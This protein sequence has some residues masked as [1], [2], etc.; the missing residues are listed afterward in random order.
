MKFSGSMKRTIA[1]SPSRFCPTA[2]ALQPGRPIDRFYREAKS[3]ALLNHPNI[4]R[5]LGVGSDQ[6]T[7]RLYLVMEYVD[8]CKR[9]WICLRQ[10]GRLAVGDAVHLALD[11]A[12]ALEH[13][14]SRNIVHRD[15]KPDNIL[16]TQSGMAKLTD[17]GLAKRTDETSHLTAAR[18][19][20][21]TPYYMPYEQALNAKYADGRSDIYALGATLYH[22]VAGEVPFPGKNPLE[23][24]EKKDI[25]E[26]LPAS[27]HNPAV[28]PALDAILNR[29]LAR[30]PGDR[31]Q[32]ASELIVDMERSR[33]ANPVPSFVDAGSRWLQ[34]SRGARA[35]DRAVLQPAAADH[36]TFLPE[37]SGPSQLRRNQPDIWY[38]RH[39]RIQKTRPL[40]QGEGDDRPVA[41]TSSGRAT[42]SSRDVGSQP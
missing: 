12:R 37:N 3:G 29:M 22:L 34:G 25:G 16:I 18:Q 20:F 42:V 11:I 32:T 39:H 30:E 33:L 2:M 36:H 40:V 15:I 41:Q 10:Y 19:G 21:G 38:L 28:P 35:L 13:C 1:M 31:Y 7:H 9:L 6:L 4:V 24:V 5:I 8:G 17:L 26:F 23:I 14:H 27:F